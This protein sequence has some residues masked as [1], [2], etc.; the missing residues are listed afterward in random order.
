MHTV[1]HAFETC[2]YPAVWLAI[3]LWVLLVPAS[4]G[5]RPLAR[6][7]PFAAALL[8]AW[9]LAAYTATSVAPVVRIPALAQ[10]AV[11][12]VPAV[13]AVVASI[14]CRLCCTCHVQIET[15]CHIAHLMSAG[16]AAHSA[17]GSLLQAALM[18][19]W[20]HIDCARTPPWNLACTHSLM[21]LFA[22]PTQQ[23]LCAHAFAGRSACTCFGR[24][25]WPWRSSACSSQQQLPSPVWPG[26]GCPRLFGGHDHLHTIMQLARPNAVQ[27]LTWAAQC[28]APS[29]IFYLLRPPGQAFEQQLCSP[30][31]PATAGACRHGGCA[32]GSPPVGSSALGR[33]L[34]AGL[35][36]PTRLGHPHVATRPAQRIS[37]RSAADRLRGGN[38]PGIMPIC[39]IVVESWRQSSVQ[40]HI[41]SRVS[42]VSGDEMPVVAVADVALTLA[43]VLRRTGVS[44]SLIA[45]AQRLSGAVSEDGNGAVADGHDGGTGGELTAPLLSHAIEAVEEEPAVRLQMDL[46]CGSMLHRDGGILACLFM[47]SRSGCMLCRL[48]C[49]APDVSLRAAGT[50]R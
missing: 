32:V 21:S 27:K 49:R 39:F 6:A 34:A 44:S 48:H 22:T 5:A 23:A 43:S 3:G 45:A 35:D 24:R 33:H 13:V 47:V 17:A 20:F 41:S 36:Q 19:A 25:S 9:L 26:V 28:F 40:G 7:S 30:Q 12:L 46:S 10:C 1:L 4:A 29:M 50:V 38:S 2:M 8:L 31:K 16:R 37:I 42:S 15:F 18:C 11:H 14:Q